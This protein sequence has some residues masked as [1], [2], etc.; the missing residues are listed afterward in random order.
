MI[1]SEVEIQHGFGGGNKKF[2]FDTAEKAG[3][4]IWA[5]QE[6]KNYI[7]FKTLMYS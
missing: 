1:W 5:R 7:L 4:V 6:I 2:M 3:G